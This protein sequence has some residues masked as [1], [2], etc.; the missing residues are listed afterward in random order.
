MGLFDFLVETPDPPPPTD[1]FNWRPGSLVLDVGCGN[2]FWIGAVQQSRGRPIGLDLSTGMLAAARTT[3]PDVPLIHA[4]ATDLPFRSASFDAVLALW[5]LYHVEDKPRALAEFRRVLVIDG[6]LI[7]CTNDNAS[8]RIDQLTC[9]AIEEV[10]KARPETWYPQLD[11]NAD[12][13]ELIL[14]SVLDEV[15]VHRFRNLFRVTVADVVV[16]FVAS[17]RAVMEQH[18]PGIDVDAVLS[19]LRRRVDDEIAASGHVEIVQFRACFVA[20]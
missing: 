15:E 19:A 8:G 10:T 5:M 1:Q 17:M 13:G 4:T 6:R 7:A 20:R 18:L 3:Y 11:F 12:N 16:G 9:D 14:R 2:G